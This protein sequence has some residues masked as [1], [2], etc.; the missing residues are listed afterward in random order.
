MLDKIAEAAH[1]AV[2]DPVS[3]G[4]LSY[5]GASFAGLAVL[6]KSGKELTGRAVTAAILNSGVQGL[7]IALL[8]YEHF[9]GNPA[10]LIGL[11]LLAG[12]GSASFIGFLLALAHHKLGVT[13]EI[14]RRKDD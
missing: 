9:S 13:I 2:V 10:M 7:V 14:G 3:I 5:F 1:I 8:G 11:S 12:M 6:L 4:I